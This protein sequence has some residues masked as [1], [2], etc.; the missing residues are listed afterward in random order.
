[1]CFQKGT[2]EIRVVCRCSG[3]G[4]IV[5]KRRQRPLCKAMRH[6]LD[7]RTVELALG[8]LKRCSGRQRDMRKRC[9][10]WSTGANE[11]CRHVTLLKLEYAKVRR[12]G[13]GLRYCRREGHAVELIVDREGSWDEDCL[14]CCTRMKSGGGGRL[15][16]SWWTRKH[17]PT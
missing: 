5:S 6:A 7:S 12:C 4:S 9:S 17:G 13:D 10:E 2:L 11:R 3:V 16:G 8:Q 1:M 14:G 15:H